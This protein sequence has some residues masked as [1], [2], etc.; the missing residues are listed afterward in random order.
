M[1]EAFVSMDKRKRQFTL[2]ELLVVIAIIA[3]LA[4]MLLPA[5]NKARDRAKNI[6]CV[7]NLKQI[8]TAF[9]CYATDFSGWISGIYGSYEV[10]YRKSYIA[11]LSDY[12]GGPSYFLMQDENQR[13]DKLLPKCLFCPSYVRKANTKEWLYTYAISNNERENGWDTAIPMF[14]NFAYLNTSNKIGAFSRAYNKIIFLSD[15][16]CPAPEQNKTTSNS[17]TNLKNQP[18]YATIHARHNGG[19]NSLALDGAVKNLKHSNYKDYRLLRL[20]QTCDFQ[21]I[22]LQNETFMAR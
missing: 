2:I 6:S 3:I 12:L 8:S 15:A 11:R 18:N 1:T 21:G 14:R 20:M 9:N 13:N 16:Y 4:A 7:S 5:L 10:N 19:T 22:Y 17:L